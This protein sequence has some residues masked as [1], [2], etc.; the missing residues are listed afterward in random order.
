MCVRLAGELG[1]DPL[2]SGALAAGGSTARASSGWRSQRP[3]GKM[4]LDSA[5]WDSVVILFASAAV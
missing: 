2:R 5:P 4:G 3:A 1:C